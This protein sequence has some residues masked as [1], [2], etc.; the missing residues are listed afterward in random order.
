MMF[1]HT[2]NDHAPWYIVL[3]DDKKRARLNV[4]SHIL[5]QIPYKN[6]NRAKGE[7]AG[8]VGREEYDDRASIA[9]RRLAEQRY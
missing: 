6:V 1:E 3:S 8:P 2:D 7:V 4:I 9:G 5:S